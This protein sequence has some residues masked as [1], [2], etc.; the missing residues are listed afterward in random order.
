MPRKIGSFFEKLTGSIRFDEN[1]EKELTASEDKDSNKGDWME[2][3]NDEG[4]LMIDVYQTPDEIII[5]TMTAGVNLSDL[6]VTIT[7][8][9]V[10]IR[11]TRS[12]ENAVEDG[13]YFYKELYWGVFSRTILLP[14]EVDID[15]AEAVEKHGLVTIKLPKLDK[16]KTQR[17]KVR[18]A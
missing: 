10:T 2:A 16:E 5:K 18:S 15:Q 6:T 7:R 3:D 1:E 11:G 12:E 4:Q 14:Q 8:D 17:L 13:D 9:M